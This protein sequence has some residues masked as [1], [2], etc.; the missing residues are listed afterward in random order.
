MWIVRSAVRFA[1]LNDNHYTA[2]LYAD[3]RRFDR[4]GLFAHLA[5]LAR[6]LTISRFARPRDAARFD[7]GVALVADYVARGGRAG[8]GS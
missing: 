1:R 2:E 7:E 6:E 5:R 4:A 3:A 8:T